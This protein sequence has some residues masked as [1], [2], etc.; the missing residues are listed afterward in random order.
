MSA[1]EAPTESSSAEIGSQPAAQVS[2]ERRQEETEAAAE[3]TLEQQVIA[4]FTRH[5]DEQPIKFGFRVVKDGLKHV[6]A[7][8]K[9]AD[10]HKIVGQDLEDLKRLDTFLTRMNRQ[11]Y[12]S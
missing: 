8:H 11:A 5:Q 6:K 9:A 7:L 10:R 4:D 1:E 3:Q 12:D 2:A